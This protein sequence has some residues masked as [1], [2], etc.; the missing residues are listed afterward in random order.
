MLGSSQWDWFNININ[1]CN[2][3]LIAAMKQSHN[4][5]LPEISNPIKIDE[6]IINQDGGYIAHCKEGIKKDFLKIKIL[7]N[8]QL[9]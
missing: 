8:I 2:K 6:F 7:K 3:I 9:Y 5:F 1:R 4:Y